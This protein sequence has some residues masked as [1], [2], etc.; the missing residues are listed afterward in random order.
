MSSCANTDYAYALF[1]VNIVIYL[2]VC[3][4][5][6]ELE[7][8]VVE[9]TRVVAERDALAAQIKADALTMSD[10][11]HHATKQG[12]GCVIYFYLFT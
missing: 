3:L 4:T 7:A 5:C 12:I 8:V 9:L 6:S 1:L 2:V 10:K 11:I